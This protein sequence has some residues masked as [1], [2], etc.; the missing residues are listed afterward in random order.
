MAKRMRGWMTGDRGHGVRVGV[1]IHCA[2]SGISDRVDQSTVIDGNTFF[3]CFSMTATGRLAISDHHLFSTLGRVIP[4]SNP[5]NVYRA[6]ST[7]VL[8]SGMQPTSS[9]SCSSVSW[10]PAELAT[11]VGFFFPRRMLFR[12]PQA[13]C[14]PDFRLPCR[15]CLATDE[16]IQGDLD[17]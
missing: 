16:K 15:L 7:S 8:V 12:F 5:S 11:S 2:Q 1:V 4:S 6:W 13:V 14:S 10:S 9:Q 3:A 17:R